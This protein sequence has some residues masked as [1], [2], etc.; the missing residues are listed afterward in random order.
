MGLDGCDYGI[1]LSA[2][3]AERLRESLRPFVAATRRA[4]SEGRRTRTIRPA[5]GGAAETAAIRAWAKKHGHL[6]STRGRIPAEIRA[7]YHAAA[8]GQ[9]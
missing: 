5:H 4:I 2:V 8:G 6:V 7:A 3:G 9:A 1:D